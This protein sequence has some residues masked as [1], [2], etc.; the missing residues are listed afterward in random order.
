M[1]L[2]PCW[3]ATSGS[4]VQE[5]PHILWNSNVHYCV[6]DNPSLIHIASQMNPFHTKRSHLP[7]IY[8]TIIVLGLLS[9]LFPSGFTTKSLHTF[10]FSSCAPSI[11]I[12]SSHLSQDFPITLFQSRI[13]ATKL[14]TLLSVA[15]G[16]TRPAHLTHLDFALLS[17]SSEESKSW[18]LSYILIWPN[19]P[20]C[21]YCL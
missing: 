8:Y 5:F 20:R 11:L 16:A 15:V 2:C 13:A 1:Y 14:Q 18:S 10:L 6:Q 7:E 9:W 21:K 4:A 3:K 12:S 17:W 19:L